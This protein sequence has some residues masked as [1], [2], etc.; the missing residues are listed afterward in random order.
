MNVTF[1]KTFNNFRLNI[2]IIQTFNPFWIFFRF[3]SNRR[4][5]IFT[6]FWAYK[7]YY[8]FGFML[9]VFVILII[10]TVCVTIVCTYFLLNAE[11]YRWQW[12]SFLAAASTAFYVY[13]YSFYYFIF[14][15]KWVLRLHLSEL[16]FF[17]S[18]DFAMNC[19]LLDSHHSFK[20]KIRYLR[21]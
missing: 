1:L 17:L 4:Y 7:I 5:F 9:L 12:T 11:D 8:V 14:K 16:Q 19:Y 10:V 15:T 2:V 6:S 18:V 3:F 21:K 13:L 20:G